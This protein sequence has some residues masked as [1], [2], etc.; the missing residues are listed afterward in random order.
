[1]TILSAGRSALNG[2]SGAALLLAP[3][4]RYISLSSKNLERTM[5]KCKI[6][7]SIRSSR[8]SVFTTN[9]ARTK[10]NTV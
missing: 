3:N 10:S 2:Y 9:I 5:P 1:M 6:P 8:H 4:L 7:Y